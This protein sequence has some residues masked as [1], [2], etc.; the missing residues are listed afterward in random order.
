[1]CK[2]SVSTSHRSVRSRL[3]VRL[4]L[5]D[6]WQHHDRSIVGV[7]TFSCDVSDHVPADRWEPS[8]LQTAVK[9]LISMFSQ[10][11]LIISGRMVWLMREK[12]KLWL[13]ITSSYDLFG[14]PIIKISFQQKLCVLR[15]ISEYHMSSACSDV[16]AKLTWSIRSVY[17]Q[18]LIICQESQLWAKQT[19]DNWSDGSPPAITVNEDWLTSLIW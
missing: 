9:E 2:W 17:A 12:E 3:H 5:S 11:L 6:F 19:V 10:Q 16:T 4:L 18:E 1:M 15:W 8:H 13:L 7:Y 14:P